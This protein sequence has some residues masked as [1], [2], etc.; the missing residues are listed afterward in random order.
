MAPSRLTWRI[1]SQRLAKLQQIR[2]GLLIS[3]LVRDLI[4]FY[5]RM[6]QMLHCRR[7][8]WPPEVENICTYV[9]SNYG[10]MMSSSMEAE[11][12]PTTVQTTKKKIKML[13]NCTRNF[14]FVSLDPTGCS[15]EVNI[16]MDLKGIG[17]E[18]GLDSTD[19]G[20]VPFP[21]SFE[22][23]RVYWKA[24]ETLSAS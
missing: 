16:R 18:S 20:W 1:P 8:R 11:F 14:K 5:V 17:C 23:L 10:Q 19:S 9:P 13:W 3:K 12:D 24:Y 2:V 4:S 21:G 6:N 15:W 7:R 22:R